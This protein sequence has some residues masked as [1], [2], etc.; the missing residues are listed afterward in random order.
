MTR[1]REVISQAR[2]PAHWKTHR[3]LSHQIPLVGRP[4]NLRSFMKKSLQKITSSPSILSEGMFHSLV[5]CFFV[6][7]DSVQLHSLKLTAKAPENR[8]KPKSKDYVFQVSTI[9]RV[10]SLLVLGG[11]EKEDKGSKYQ[12]HS[13]SIT[14]SISLQEHHWMIPIETFMISCFCGS[15]LRFVDNF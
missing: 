3:V 14:G 8:P 4:T 6:S 10:N 13:S 2:N 9:F 7:L 12:Y 1:R 15:S 5:T 11:H